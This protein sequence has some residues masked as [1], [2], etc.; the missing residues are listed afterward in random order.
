[1]RVR[2]ALLAV[3]GVLG[4]TSAHAGDYYK[5]TDA[6]GTVHYSQTPP[7]GQ[8]AKTVYVNDNAPTSLPPGFGNQPETTQQKAKASENRAALR[9]ANTEA[10]AANC[11]DAKGNINVL[12]GRRMVAKREN[13]P[14]VRALTPEQRKQALADSRAQADTYC[15]KKP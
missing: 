15:T 1:M 7:P 10:V 5:W 12:G 3:L 14:D 2:L 9:K 8:A 11:T 6:Q 4:A 13:N